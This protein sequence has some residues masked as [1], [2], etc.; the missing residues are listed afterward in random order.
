MNCSSGNALKCRRVGGGFAIN[1]R[2]RCVRGPM[3]AGEA[4]GRAVD[5]S[6]VEPPRRY[7]RDI[8]ECLQRK[9]WEAIYD[10]DEGSYSVNTVGASEQF[11]ADER[12]CKAA[13]GYTT[14]PPLTDE[15]LTVLYMHQLRSVE[16][17]RE[18]GFQ[19]PDPPSEQA[20]KDTY[21]TPEEYSAHRYAL[22]TASA[23]ERRRILRAC[24]RLPQG[25]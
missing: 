6:E 10:D 4:G 16:C 20:Y 2:S 13:T 14:R 1:T 21:G 23:V 18:L 17:L 19:V 8:A 15:Q 7:M 24:P 5:L 25:W 9:G 22:R 12:E 11:S 3:S